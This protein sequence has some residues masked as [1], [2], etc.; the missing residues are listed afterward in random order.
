MPLYGRLE[1]FEGDGSTWPIYKEQVHVFFRASNTP[2]ENQRDIFLAG[3]GTE[4]FSLLLNILKPATPRTKTLSECLTARRPHF[5]PA[6]FTLLRC[7]RFN[8][9]SRREGEYVAEL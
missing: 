4:V 1:P 8:N 3:S 7:F 5:S 9:R 6:S 2:E